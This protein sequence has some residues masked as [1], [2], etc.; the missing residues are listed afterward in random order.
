MKKSNVVAF[1]GF[2]LA[3]ALVMAVSYQGISNAADATVIKIWDFS[4]KTEATA[5]GTSLKIDPQVVKI[6][7]D[8][9]VVWVNTAY[10]SEVKVIFE[11]AKRCADLVSNPRDFVT[12]TE[13]NCF[14]TTFMPYG[15]TSSLVFPEP[16]VFKYKVQSQDGALTT[17]GT[18]E[19]AK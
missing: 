19:V 9:I 13:S 4:V 5:A 12:N 18:I 10:F 6:P 2:T 7:K 17:E 15:A 14:V 11:E 16:G 8:G 1:W 3:F